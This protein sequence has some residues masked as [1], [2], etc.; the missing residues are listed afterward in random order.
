MIVLRLLQ[1]L[2]ALIA[3]FAY[4]QEQRSD[5]HRDRLSQSCM[6]YYLIH[7]LQDECCYGERTES[8]LS[9]LLVAQSTHANRVRGIASKA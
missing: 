3:L 7:R 9:Y 2:N 5:Q 6:L 4:D 1:S 8:V